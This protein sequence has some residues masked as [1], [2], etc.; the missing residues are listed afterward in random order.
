MTASVSLH[1]R[2]RPGTGTVVGLV[3][4]CVLSFVS[5]QRAGLFTS[6]ERLLQHAV[7]K[8]PR[9]WAAHNDLGCLFALQS[10]Y[11]EAVN[12]FQ[13]SLTQNPDYLEAHVNLGHALLC[14]QRPAEAEPHFATVLRHNPGHSGAHRG[15]AKIM[16]MR[17]LNHDAISHFRAALRSKPDA[18]THTD[19]AS[20]LY[21]IGDHRGAVAELRLALS[22]N[23]TNI[24]TLN[25]LAWLLATAPEAD[26]R[27]G[28]EA[29]TRA[30]EACILTDFK[31]PGLLGTLAAA[32]AEAGHF[33]KA[34]YLADK[35]THLAASSGQE[36]FAGI[37]RELLKLYR[38]GQAYHEATAKSR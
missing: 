25:N 26:L 38:Q 28:A 33:R 6:E 19:L 7:A 21:Q 35:A 3:V 11:P 23:A 36:Q 18:Q 17:N 1:E 14:L 16:T 13:T 24:E 9:A 8:N 5:F 34:V 27:N 29:V 10:K 15:L 20:A 37:S 31:Q 30:R 32:H 12:H 4:V 2:L 22:L